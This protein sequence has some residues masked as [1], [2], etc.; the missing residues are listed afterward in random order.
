M[1]LSFVIPCYRSAKTIGIV[2]EE[3]IGILKETEYEYEIILVN[4]YSPDDVWAVIEALAKEHSFIKGISLAK[5]FGQHAALLAGYS[6]CRGDYVISL[7][8]DGQIPVNY[9]FDLINKI[10]EGYDVVYA[11]YEKIERGLFRRFGTSMSAMLSK[12]ILEAPKG[13]RG[14]SFY[15][16][17]KFVVEEMIKYRHSF[18]YL[19]GLILRTTKNIACIPVEHRKRLQ[20]KSGYSFKKLLSLWINGVTAFSVKPLE[21]GIFIGF[22]TS[23]LGWLSALIIIIRKFMG[24]SV[25]LGWSSTIA[26]I[27]IIGGTILVMLGLVGEYI[28][29]IYICINGAPQYVIKEY[30]EEYREDSE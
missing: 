11:Y 23:A 14:S 24:V 5:N 2:V 30:T 17:R 1:K 28:G 7:D 26:I 3:I 9:I 22:I 18:P 27:L 10:E 12:R 29:R 4:D 19:T 20:G 16:A 21:I 13:F 6:H 8:D 15:V 25:L